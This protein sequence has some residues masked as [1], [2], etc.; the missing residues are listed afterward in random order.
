MQFHHKK[1]TFVPAMKYKTY[2][3]KLKYLSVLRNRY[4]FATL[5]FVVWMVFIDNNNMFE[6]FRELRQI[7]NLE[8]DA[9]YYQHEIE[10]NRKSLEELRTNDNNLEKFAREQYLMKRSDEELFIIIE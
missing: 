1:C 7:K 8:K 3:S 6:H 9:V 5:A 10:Y 2:L 4:V